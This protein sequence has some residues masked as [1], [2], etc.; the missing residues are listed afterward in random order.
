MGVMFDESKDLVKK[1]VATFKKEENV[2]VVVFPGRSTPAQDDISGDTTT[3]NCQSATASSQINIIIEEDNIDQ[4]EEELEV[5]P[6]SS[7]ELVPDEFR[8]EIEDKSISTKGEDPGEYLGHF[9]P[10]EGTGVAVA[11]F[12]LTHLEKYFIDLSQLNIAFTDGTSKMTGVNT[13]S[14][15]CLRAS[16]RA[17]TSEGSLLLPSP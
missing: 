4:A 15:T 13:G 3:R 2:S 5:A 1:I 7:S 14:V 12:L 16:Y 9:T 10:D 8:D 6:S 11:M 17:T